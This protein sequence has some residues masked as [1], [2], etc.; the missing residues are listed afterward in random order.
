M[1][2]PAFGR[3]AAVFAVAFGVRL[4]HLLQV[5]PTPF[6]E[7]HRTFTES[8]MHMFDQWSQRIAEGDWLGRETPHPLYR[9]QLDLAPEAEWREWY[10]HPAA[11][12]KAPLYP[13]LLA[14]LR[15]LFGDAML[16]AALLQCLA[17]SL[18]AA[19]LVRLGGRLFGP[20]AGLAAGLLFALY[21]PA[22]HFD[23]VLLRGP[24][25][26]LVSLL[27]SLSLARLA[28]DP[29][30]RRAFV[31]G[32]WVAASLLV[33]EGFL[34]APLAVLA[35]LPRWSRGLRGLAVAAGAFLGGVILGLTP[36][37]ARNLVVGA[38][39]M[40]LAVT[41]SIVYAVFNAAGANPWAFDIRPQILLPLMN[42][43]GGG[44]FGM[45]VACLGSFPGF[46]AVL[47]FY[48]E[49]LSGLFIA[50]ENPDNANFY[51]SVFLD[52]LL[53][54]LPG[55]GT[56]FPLAVA[57]F[58]AAGSRVR[59]LQPLLPYALTLLLSILLTTTLSRYRAA[60][61]VFLFPLSGLAVSAAVEAARQDRRRLALLWA[62]GLGAAALAA[63][64]EQRIEG[65]AGLRS[66]RYRPAEFYLAADAWAQRGRH[67]RAVGEMRWLV[68]HNPDPRVQAWALVRAASLLVEQGDRPQ[69][70]EALRLATGIGR[71]DAAL[72]L[73]AGD[74]RR[75]GLRE[76]VGAREL[77][78]AALALSPPQALQQQLRERLH[79]MEAAPGMQ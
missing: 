8:D 76:A 32:L 22:I 20:P 3:E 51:Y 40:K 60:F 69:A 46:A 56:L 79:S 48:A 31:L 63:L 62:C 66:L 67:D 14:G 27:A 35:I 34:P 54:V 16:P 5:A 30:P 41:G 33:N 70:E 25:I 2:R 59:A 74:L 75:G 57:G 77:Y 71:R 45:A 4:F 29:S 11:F 13:Y 18:S 72:L 43:A 28:D 61:A 68:R 38:P 64:V 55:Y 9:W 47:A 52:P 36:L 39:P 24:W 15:A 10:G 7:L 58:A 42:K 44:L 17:S 6:F 1:N 26:V 78:A 53:S 37:I 65:A 50:F 21:A 19:L 12:Y 23:A 49:K 73:A